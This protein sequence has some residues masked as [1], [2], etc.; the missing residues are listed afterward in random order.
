MSDAAKLW[1]TADSQRR[2]L[3]P[4]YTIL[5]SGELTLSDPH[6]QCRQ[7]DESAVLAFEITAQWQLG[8]QAETLLAQLR[9]GPTTG[10]TDQSAASNTADNPRQWQALLERLAG[11]SSESNDEAAAAE[12]ALRSLFT[13]FF[14]LLG[15]AAADDPARQHAT[16]TRAADLERQLDELG[17]PT[18][19]K[20]SD[21]PARI[22]QVMDQ[23]NTLS[24]AV[25][26][27]APVQTIA[28]LTALTPT[29]ADDMRYIRVLGYHTANDGGGG[30]FYWQ[31]NSAAE[32]NGGTFFAPDNWQ[33]RGRWKRVI[34]SDCIN[35]RWFGA[36][37]G[38]QHDATNAIQ[39][40]LAAA[41]YHTIPRVRL[42][43][44]GDGSNNFF[45]ISR[46]L[47]IPR[48]HGF[49][50]EGLGGKYGSYLIWAGEP[51]ETMLWVGPR[52]GDPAHGQ[53]GSIIRGITLDGRGISG[54][55]IRITGGADHRYEQLQVVDCTDY[56][57]HIGHPADGQVDYVTTLQ[58][59][60][61][62]GINILS[63]YDPA[64]TGAPSELIGLY[65]NHSASE[66]LN[67]TS[68][69]IGCEQ[70]DGMAQA[71]FKP[72][73]HA[74]FRGLL[75]TVKSTRH[76][77]VHSYGPIAISEWS[78]EDFMPLKVGGAGQTRGSVITGANLRS[79]NP[80]PG[81]FAIDWS[82]ANHES[83][84]L[85]DGVHIHPW[86][87]P[88]HINY[89]GIDPNVRLNGSAT[90]AVWFQKNSIGQLGDIVTTSNTRGS[91]FVKR[92]DDDERYQ[93]AATPGST[94]T[95]HGSPERKQ[96]APVGA[97][98]VDLDGGEGRVLYVKESG[99]GPVGW[100]AK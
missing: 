9:A 63:R 6:N 67:F 88:E 78:S 24:G 48:M 61:F 35:V 58:N 31:A 29:T 83:C 57:I 51:G 66:T 99:S 64:E 8:E 74:C 14:S 49:V 11:D 42:G 76:Y 17:I 50:F 25:K 70:M 75:T 12:R 56:G 86:G 45:H 10:S 92:D 87:N 80:S 34:D 32:V 52:E 37:G 39:A 100:V 94:I 89:T 54:T 7:V 15:D 43:A 33:G 84:L 91:I 30:I 68:V 60:E 28:A 73:G 53:A 77:A 82:P 59:A 19:G 5:P 27:N 2:F 13:G 46:T 97:L 40:A 26:S 95:G 3:I 44:D 72:T 4:D 69:G 41:E 55:G 81:K 90:G 38:K 20:L 36:Q 47:V 98:Y 96:V 23:L 85:L 79:T 71:I 93:G 22:R 18:N 65:I 21:L 62:N 1:T 16:E